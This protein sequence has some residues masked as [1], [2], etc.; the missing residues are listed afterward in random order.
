MVAMSSS[1]TKLTAMRAWVAALKAYD[2][3]WTPFQDRTA[4]PPGPAEAER[5][6]VLSAQVEQSYERYHRL[7]WT[8]ASGAA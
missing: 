8:D 3:A 4:P 2:E 6:A 5:L 7:A 1:S